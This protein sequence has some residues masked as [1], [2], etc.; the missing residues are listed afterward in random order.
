MKKVFFTFAIFSF[1]FAVYG[2]SKEAD[3]QVLPGYTSM[4]MD[5]VE[6]EY[7]DA[8][9]EAMLALSN[10]N[11]QNPINIYINKYKDTKYDSTISIDIPS[12]Q[13]QTGEFR[14]NSSHYEHLKIF[15]IGKN[16][17]CLTVYSAYSNCHFTFLRIKDNKIISKQTYNLSESRS[18]E[19]T[20]FA[21][22]GKDTI[23]FSYN[24]QDDFTKT[25]WDNWIIAF[26]LN[27][28][29]KNSVK[30]YS[31][32]RDEIDNMIA[33]PDYV[34]LTTTIYSK[35]GAYYS[36]LKLSADLKTILEVHP[37]NYGVGSARYVE[38]CDNKEK[39]ILSY[40]VND[41]N[42]DSQSWVSEFSTDGIFNTS[43]ILNE[44]NKFTGEDEE[45]YLGTQKY[46]KDGIY[47]SGYV[48]T[49]EDI[50]FTKDKPVTFDLNKYVDYN[51]KEAYVFT[52]S[53]KYKSSNR[54]YSNG[55]LFI[56]DSYNYKNNGLSKIS[57]HIV[58]KDKQKSD[59]P[60]YEY[61]K[62]DYNAFV[63][64]EITE[65]K[66]EK[67]KELLKIEDWKIQQED[68]LAKSSVIKLP[69][70]YALPDDEDVISTIP[71]LPFSER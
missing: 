55:K 19:S 2:Q 69:W 65:E 18:Y 47:L 12:E 3:I 13:F 6:S 70:I 54:I 48:T 27:G 45:V 50:F 43:Y 10:D 53:S 32:F 42:G 49:W 4:I 60:P 24:G 44:T 8:I 26:D 20:N 14:E 67:V 66:S 71:V 9:Y 17:F 62:S 15:P 59:V 68:S 29:I 5:V 35:I 58:L 16:E 34:Y 39:L 30:F 40:S 7:D 63:K 23:Y 31:E 25:N 57:Y 33:F 38:F 41:E 21:F 51:F 37:Y 28:N 11:D 64:D 61:V 1:I 36:L 22:N 56:S 52:Y 46:K